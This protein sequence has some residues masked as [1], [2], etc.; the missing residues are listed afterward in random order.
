MTDWER[1]WPYHQLVLVEG[2][3]MGSDA[4]EAS[5]SEGPVHEVF[6]EGFYIGK[7]P[8]TQDLWEGVMGRNPAR[9]KGHSRPVESVTWYDT[10]QFLQKLN[11]RTGK[12][13][14][15]PTEAEW[16][17]AARGGNRSE[18]YLYAGS[19]R[20][21][22]VGWYERNSKRQTHPVGRKLGNE[23]G[24]H[25]M[26]GNVREWVEDQWH[27]SYK[28]AP[29][30]GSTWADQNTNTNRVRRGGGWSNS[31]RNCRVSSRRYNRPGAR[32][33]GIGFRLAMSLQA[34]G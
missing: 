30:D 20:L 19:D 27:S 7:Y 15:L 2:F 22:E 12:T 11:E 18:G 3:H 17:Y 23:L 26:S 25:D 5:S 29:T 33:G 1:N 14:R 16:E 21:E 31:A 10:Q 6:L 4:E 28:G 8:V 13:Y 32:S 34:G 24:I 9:F